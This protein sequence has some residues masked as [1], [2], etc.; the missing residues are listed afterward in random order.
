MGGCLKKKEAEVPEIPEKG[1]GSEDKSAVSK[2]REHQIKSIIRMPNEGLST[3]SGK[4]TLRT[5]TTIQPPIE[6]RVDPIK[7]VF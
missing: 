7:V 5:Y 6:L 2:R 4:S 3:I 1:V